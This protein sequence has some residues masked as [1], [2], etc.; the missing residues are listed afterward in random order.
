MK[1][2]VDTSI[3]FQAL[4]RNKPLNSYGEVGEL[5]E[6][7]KEVRVQLIGPIL[8][9]TT[10]KKSIDTNYKRNLMYLKLI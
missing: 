10:E 1:V 4:R 7:I 8:V 6:L 2:L 9:V 5:Q 3:W